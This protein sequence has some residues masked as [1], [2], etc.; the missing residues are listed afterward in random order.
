MTTQPTK[1]P[2]ASNDLTLTLT[3]TDYL[4]AHLE[5]Q[6]GGENGFTRSIRAVR[7]S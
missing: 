5:A 1:L 2:N 6:A 7:V 4:A 3:L